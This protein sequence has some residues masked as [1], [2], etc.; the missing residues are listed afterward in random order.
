MAYALNPKVDPAPGVAIVPGTSR[1]VVFSGKPK[2]NQKKATQKDLEAFFKAGV[3]TRT[4]IPL[5][6]Q[7]ADVKAD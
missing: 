2:N 5:V 4:G 6:I 1:V 7:I 3:K